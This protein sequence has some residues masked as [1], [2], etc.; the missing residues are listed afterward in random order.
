MAAAFCTASACPAASLGKLTMG[1]S[2]EPA[3]KYI[4]GWLADLCHP[5]YCA[6][7]LSSGLP[8]QE[9]PVTIAEKHKLFFFSLFFAAGLGDAVQMPLCICGS[10][11]QQSG[12]MSNCAEQRCRH[13]SGENCQQWG[14]GRAGKGAGPGAK[15][16]KCRHSICT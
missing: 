9:A 12:C 10:S 5:E 1:P 14:K 6:A 13:E 2:Y 7:D 3:Y 11:S 8:P 4:F 16:P 15:H